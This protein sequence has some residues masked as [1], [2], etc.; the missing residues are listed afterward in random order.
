MAR[1]NKRKE[2]TKKIKETLNIYIA[3][4]D[5]KGGLRYIKKL[6]ESYGF[7]PNNQCYSP[8]T[9]DLKNLVSSLATHKN[10]IKIIFVD[11]DDKM[12]S[13]GNRKNVNDGK[14]I[15]KS[16]NIC[17]IVSNE[18]LELWFLLHFKNQTAYIK[19][20]DIFKNLIQELLQNKKNVLSKK[21]INDLKNH[22]IKNIDWFEILDEDEKQK[23]INR[24]RKLIKNKSPLDPW[25]ENPITLMC[26]FIDFLEKLKN[27]KD[28]K[29]IKEL[30]E[31]CYPMTGMKINV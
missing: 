18:C 27:L 29:Q 26:C 6:I 30:I 25:Q 15:A 4:E 9:T 23:A 3:C 14:Q 13:E 28:K 1:K 22:K 11:V 12:K 24:C 21:E 16:N 10:E 19:R 17:I 5:S 31:K 2:K 7:M 8:H 20:E